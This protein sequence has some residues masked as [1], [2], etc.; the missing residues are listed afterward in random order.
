MR[1]IKRLT[2]V[3]FALCMAVAGAST[4]SASVLVSS[5]TQT[6][7]IAFGDYFSMAEFQSYTP[8]QPFAS[9]HANSTVTIGG[10][11]VYGQAE[12]NGQVAW[13]IFDGTNLLTP[14]PATASVSSGQRG[15][16]DISLGMVL[17]AGHTYTMGLAA[18]NMFAW[19]RGYGAPDVSSA[20]GTLT[21]LGIEPIAGVYTSGYDPFLTSAPAGGNFTL[22]GFERIPEWDSTDVRGSLRILDAGGAL[23]PIP[24]PSEWAMLL[25][26]LMVVGFVAKRQ[27][28]R[29]I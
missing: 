23:P 5:H 25:A 28:R 17:Q 10:F 15:W 6:G 19:G 2:G 22:G 18:N 29:T 4:A 14:S 21:I 8:F 12:A 1:T 7:N 20:D 16:F 24:E 26:G 27:R 11:G 9:V 3:V 13:V